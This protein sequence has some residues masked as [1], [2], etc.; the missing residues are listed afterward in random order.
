MSLVTTT[1]TTWEAN[2]AQVT[3]PAT[4]QAK[5]LSIGDELVEGADAE[6]PI[7]ETC[8][9]CGHDLT[10]AAADFDP[11]WHGSYAHDGCEDA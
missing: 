1:A 9:F 7:V 10:I 6:L 2:H 4:A 5:R 8:Q 3:T 11:A